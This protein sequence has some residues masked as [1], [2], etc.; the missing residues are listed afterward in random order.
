MVLTM[1]NYKLTLV[2]F[3]NIF[4]VSNCIILNSKY[5]FKIELFL[6]IDEAYTVC[7]KKVLIKLPSVFF[8]TVH[9]LYVLN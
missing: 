1:R 8:W 9:S 3:S 4:I 2:I 6:C 5:F 7:K